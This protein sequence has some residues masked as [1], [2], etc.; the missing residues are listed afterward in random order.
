MIAV[1]EIKDSI[2]DGDRLPIDELVPSDLKG[3]ISDCWEDNPKNRP[4]FGEILERLSEPSNDIRQQKIYSG[5]QVKKVGKP[6]APSRKYLQTEVNNMQRKNKIQLLFVA[7]LALLLIGGAVG[8][9][10]YLSSN[11][12]VTDPSSGDTLSITASTPTKTSFKISRTASPT[13]TVST[14]VQDAVKLAGV[15]GITID[16]NDNLYVILPASSTNTRYPLVYSINPNNKDQQLTLVANL[17]TDGNGN[18]FGEQGICYFNKTL[19]VPRVGQV[20]KIDLANGNA[21]SKFTGTGIASTGTA[22]GAPKL[23]RFCG[24]THCIADKEGNIIVAEACGKIRKVTQNGYVSTIARDLPAQ[25]YGF[26]FNGTNNLIFTTWKIVYSINLISRE[27]YPI[28]G[29]S[30]SLR[31]REGQGLLSQFQ[32]IRGIVF[33]E[34]GNLVIADLHEHLIARANTTNYVKKFGG[35]G[36]SGFLDSVGAAIKMNGPR[37]LV[38][39][40]Q[41]RIFYTES[42]SNSIRMLTW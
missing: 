18:R 29:N 38:F 30:S 41:G 12:N 14:L 15:N 1:A 20:T 35:N 11:K 8:V 24:A 19:Y 2:K 25:P 28:L 6:I 39:D 7:V 34:L 37:H 5:G 26:T 22:D 23:A 33:D 32:S 9:G 17:S 36:G 42:R 4:T 40:S 21:V 3:L 27:Y 13:A 10:L 31:F 16:E